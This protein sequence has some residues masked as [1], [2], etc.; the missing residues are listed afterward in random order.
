[1]IL[2]IHFTTIFILLHFPWIL[3]G[4]SYKQLDNITSIMNNIYIYIKNTKGPKNI[5]CLII[6]KTFI[7]NEVI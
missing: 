4:Q 7:K 3:K 6:M 1:M 5:I 2:I